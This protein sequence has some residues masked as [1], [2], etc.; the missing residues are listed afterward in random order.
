MRLLPLLSF[1]VALA[2]VAVD[3][4]TLGVFVVAN[5]ILLFF[6]IEENHKDAREDIISVL[7]GVPLV[8]MII[9]LVFFVTSENH[10]DTR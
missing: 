3:A 9:N 4:D 10:N 6:S 8:S 7:P 5:M 1:F 2:F